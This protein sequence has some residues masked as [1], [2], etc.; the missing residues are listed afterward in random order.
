MV[1]RTILD[2]DDDNDHAHER[3]DYDDNADSN[4][5][6]DKDNTYYDDYYTWHKYQAVKYSHV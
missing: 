3:F 1:I 5:N 4:D 6:K 2:D